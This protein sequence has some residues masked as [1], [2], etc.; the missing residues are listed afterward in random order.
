MIGVRTVRWAMNDT[1]TEIRFLLND[2]EVRLSKVG[3]SDTL[4][5]F[6]RL[7]QQL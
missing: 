6:L 5:D 4:L 7:D 3:P 1:R 2:R